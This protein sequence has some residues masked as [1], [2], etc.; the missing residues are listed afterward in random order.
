MAATLPLLLFSDSDYEPLGLCLPMHHAESSFL[1]IAPLWLQ[2]SEL[3]ILS[4]SLGFVVM[5]A[6]TTVPIDCRWK[7]SAARLHLNAMAKPCLLDP[8]V[9]PT[10]MV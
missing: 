8:N 5:S 2:P 3:Q 10:L 4:P 6:E 7:C 1:F 9:D